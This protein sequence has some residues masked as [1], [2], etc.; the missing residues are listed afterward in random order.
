MIILHAALNDRQ[1]YLWGE[2]SDSATTASTAAVSTARRNTK[3]KPSKSKNLSVL[4]LPFGADAQ[5]IT[6]ALQQIGCEPGS[7]EVKTV[8]LW[9]PTVS[10]FP[11]ASS[12]LIAAPPESNEL[13]ELAAW[14]CEALSVKFADVLHLLGCCTGRALLG[15]GVMAGADLQFWALA[16]RFA[17]ALVARQQFLPGVVNDGGQW[18]ACWQAI[19]AGADAQRLNT[20]AS[21][22]PHACRA[23]T[24]DS[25]APPAI[26]ATKVLCTFLDVVVEHLVR[27]NLS[28]VSQ[29]LSSPRKNPTRKPATS[30][31]VF[32]SAH[33]QWLHALGSDEGVL[34]GDAA[35][36][37]NL[38]EQ[39]REWRRPISLASSAPWRLCLR[40]EEPAAADEEKP[41][42]IDSNGTWQV[43]YLLQALDDPSLLVPA[44]QAWH[45]RGAG[46]QALKR[47]GF[48]VQEFLLS[49]LGQAAR[50][51]PQVESSLQDAQPAGYTLDAVGAHDFL[52]RQA[53]LFEQAGFNVLLPSWWARQGGK[54]TLAA[55]ATVK[56]PPMQGGSGLSLEELVKFEWEV[57]LGDQKLSLR[58]LEALARL[59]APLVRFRGQWVQL[60]AEEIEAALAFWK[61]RQQT[62]GTLRD[63]VRLA[64]GAGH[65]STSLPFAGIEAQGW[66]G[67]WLQQLQ[68]H[69]GFE[70]LAPPSGFRAQLR[71]YQQ[72]G[73]SWLHFLRQWG[74]GA[75]LADDMGLGKTIQMLALW[76][77][78]RENGEKRPS[79]L[80]CPT[81]VVANWAREA[82]RFAPE[83]PVLIHHGGGRLQG[84]QF[85]KNAAKHALVLSSYG[86]LHRDFEVLQG[87]KWA[88]VVLDEAQNIKNPYTK[89]AQAAR[90]LEAD[91]KI[92]LTGTPVENNVGDLWSIMEFLNP[93]LLGRQ[94]EFKRRFFVPIQTGSDPEATK[95]LQRLTGPFILRRLKT[96]KAVIADLPDK[97]EMKVF[98]SLTKEQASLYAA[99]VED[100][101]QGLESSDGIQR[102][103]LV[104]ATLMKLKQVCNHPVQMLG[105]NSRIDGR[106][107]KLARLSEML[108]EVLAVNERALIFT[109]FRKMGDILQRHLQETFGREVL[110][111]HGGVTKKARDRMVER[112]QQEK[113]PPLFILSLKAGGVGLNL[114]NANHV[115]HFDRW[116][117]PAVENQATD[118]AFRIGQTRNVQVHKFVCAGTF[119]EK[120][121]E[122]IER[123]Q[124][125]AGRT[126][127][128][129]EAW[130]TELSTTQLQELFALRNDAVNE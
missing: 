124:E 21:S 50:V 68:N 17:G 27:Q 66:I 59:K 1:F 74:L 107:G 69:A 42:T 4:S 71:P 126:V 73:Y 30:R 129:G 45:S 6:A 44:E 95:Q 117:N 34:D 47:P 32:E 49:S 57:A 93:G 86:L 125:I 10:D 64:L 83:L 99:V 85:A 119:E 67:D 109:Q 54:A 94:S 9:L 8:Q 38:A 90:A 106:S 80:I 24:L 76:Q 29:S 33:D 35:Q 75:C 19:Y 46:A 2:T 22:L 65:E 87:V 82:S 121:D 112:F 108:E 55:R 72:R 79:L 31:P 48:R 18:R 98:C 53:W 118:R 102:K 16:A 101:A 130:L 77:R 5:S 105:D 39:V 91:Y 40:L 25:T 104:L 81:S 15:P 116:W 60:N 11:L 61:K 100:A 89:Q 88:G 20:L 12:P 113:A 96:D 41:K 128:T 3:S 92:A 26:P 37:Q 111:L 7:G 78:E 84:K 23:L 97:M 63:V 114:T 52:T 58:E 115:F 122:M 110:F 28:P 103:G 62:D 120:I 127:G 13:A 123:K 51:S 70:E 43:S 36:W 14:N 56:S